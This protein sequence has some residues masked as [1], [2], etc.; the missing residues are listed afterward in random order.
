ESVYYNPHCIASD[1]VGFH[2]TSD[3]DEILN[4]LLSISREIVKDNEY[5][6]ERILSVMHDLEAIR[7]EKALWS[8]EDWQEY[9]ECEADSLIECFVDN[10]KEFVNE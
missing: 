9:L 3:E 6:A 2:D 10:W 7:E 5:L 4:E 1:C 8:D